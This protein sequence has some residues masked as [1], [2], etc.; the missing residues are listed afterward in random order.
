M[1]RERA[2]ENVSRIL[3]DAKNLFTKFETRSELLGAWNLEKERKDGYH[4]RELLELLQNVDDAYEE[5]CQ[6]KE[7]EKGKEVVAEIKFLNG[8]FSISNTGTYFT[9]TS[10][11]RLCQGGVSTKKEYYI[12]NKGTGF[13]SLL[14]W[15]KKIRVYSGDYSIQFS[16]E[17]AQKQLQEIQNSEIVKK[18]LKEKPEINFPILFAPEWLEESRKHYDTVIEIDGVNSE[19]EKSIYDQ[20]K[21]L[22]SHILLFLP[23]ITSISIET[24]NSKKV[25]TKKVRKESNL[26]IIDIHDDTGDHSFYYFQNVI[27]EDK[28][29]TIEGK[30][31]IVKL[32]LAIPF[33]RKIKY[34]YKLYTFFPIKNA[35]CPFPALLHATFNL[36]SHRDTINNDIEQYN[37]QVLKKLLKFYVSIIST[38]FCKPGDDDFALQLLCPQNFVKEKGSLGSSLSP[39]SCE[40]YYIELLKKSKILLTVNNAYISSEETPVRCKSALPDTV[41][42]ALLCKLIKSKDYIDNSLD[43]FIHILCPNVVDEQLLEKAINTLSLSVNQQIEIFVWWIENFNSS[44]LLP[45]CI[46]NADGNWIQYND[47]CFFTPETDIS[48]PSWA[49]ISFFDREYEKVLIKYCEEN[50]RK[51]LDNEKVSEKDRKNIKRVIRHYLNKFNVIKIREFS[52]KSIISPINASINGDF[53]RSIEFVKFLWTLQAI[54]NEIPDSSDEEDKSPYFFPGIDEKVYKVQE[55]YMGQEYGN[56][57]GE[58]LFEGLPLHKIISI[59]KFGIDNQFFSEFKTFLKTNGLLELPEIE[60]ST[61]ANL[62][63]QYRDN[64]IPYCDEINISRNWKTKGFEEIKVRTIPNLDKILETQNTQTILKWLISDS[65]C[66]EIT[67]KVEPNGSIVTY[68]KKGAKEGYPNQLHSGYPSYIHFVVEKTKWIII[69]DKKY[70]PEDCLIDSDNGLFQKYVPCI[71]DSYIQDLSKA[72]NV[73]SEVIKKF[74]IDVGVKEDV[75]KLS[76]SAFY[77]LLLDISEDPENSVQSFRRIITTC[78]SLPEGFIFK[79][80]DEKDKYFKQGKILARN[81]SNKDEIVPIQDVYFSS[82]AVLNLRNKYVLR[83]SAR[84]GNRKTIKN[85]FNVSEFSEDYEILPN[86]EIHKEN[87]AF[88]AQYNKFLPY[89]AAIRNETEIDQRLKNIEITITSSILVSID[90][91]PITIITPYTVFHEQKKNWYIYLSESEGL[92]NEKISECLE[93]IF[94][95]VLNFPGENITNKIG[96]FFRSE[97]KAFLLKKYDIEENFNEVRKRVEYNTKE[98][99]NKLVKSKVLLTDE[100]EILISKINFNNITVS[101]IGYFKKFIELAKIKKEDFEKEFNL[102]PTL[103]IAEH[104]SQQIANYIETHSDQIL[105][106]CYLEIKE[107][108][109]IQKHE[110]LLNNKKKKESTIL[111]PGNLIEDIS[112]SI[113]SYISSCNL[114]IDENVDIFHVFT[115]NLENLKKRCKNFDESFLNK[116]EIKSLLYFDYIDHLVNKYKEYEEKIN[117]QH[118]T[119]FDNNLTEQTDAEFVD[120]LIPSQKHNHLTGN[121]GKGKVHSAT[122]QEKSDRDNCK[123]GDSAELIVYNKLLKYENQ[124]VN[125][126][127]QNSQYEIHWVSG[128]AQKNKNFS[129]DDTLG[130]DIKCID[131]DKNR[132]LYIEVKSTTEKNCSFI[133][134]SNEYE[135]GLEKKGMYWIAFVSEIIN[136]PKIAIIKDWYDKEKFEYLSEKYTV[137]YKKKNIGETDA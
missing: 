54:K 129:G 77:R 130:Y 56:A 8:I 49:K 74:L 43:A 121:R 11:Q 31:Q 62:Y 119:I 107:K 135:F 2:K 113:D 95:V 51:D 16:E 89:V 64:L 86:K 20:I 63:G 72:I 42:G 10:I 116:N 100:I 104:N 46:K 70:A 30:E 39:F 111:N 79:P 112:F 90:K 61:P 75:T 98:I 3:E 76:S 117:K 5:L 134:S 55:L 94:H 137:S 110:E 25:I 22:D 35:D 32:A 101:E 128:A 133:M 103:A 27:S 122:A 58:M 53:N 50:R 68:Y 41:N 13:R 47:I 80:S 45:N 66:Q 28:I 131:K 1:S 36:D 59:E 37:G 19:S 93:Q 97:N 105:V 78:C 48:L 12:G 17:Y 106:N 132:V 15:G 83:T 38:Y 81:K 52:Q 127:F 6:N 123:H 57:L 96:E 34:G 85:I 7:A 4:G 87:D 84:T 60:T 14:N 115:V 126:F 26:T 114:Q 88:I 18:Q 23:N 109:D 125:N 40:T 69:D 91:E 21:T 136:S 67:N 124:E 65:I 33:D 82:G 92:N 73:K 102:W 29:K 71:T 118:E 9:D 99:I 108:N 44:L 24:N 120:E